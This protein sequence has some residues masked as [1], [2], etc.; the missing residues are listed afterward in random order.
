MVAV[1]L[2]RKLAEMV[3]GIDL[4]QFRVG[5]RVVVT[6][7]EAALLTA[8]GWAEAWPTAFEKRDH[9]ASDHR[10]IGRTH[11]TRR[12]TRQGATAQASPLTVL[13]TPMPTGFRDNAPPPGWIQAPTDHPP[14]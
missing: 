7:R 1:R 3:D 9:T 10:G 2:T 4:S 11:T 6:A 13:L 8:E 12:G 5:D 14:V